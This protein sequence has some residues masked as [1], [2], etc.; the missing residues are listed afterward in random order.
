MTAGEVAAL[1]AAVA[2]SIL[3]LGL[4]V[5]LVSLISTLRALREMTEELRRTAM[6]LMNDMRSTVTHA[7]TELEKVDAL[8]IRA[9][10]ISTTVDSASR[11][12]YLAFSSPLV[13][14]IAFSAGAARA[15]QRLGQRRAED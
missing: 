11:L 13:K 14:A 6:P 10:S 1:V 8:L 4:L 9:D 12:V 2:I 15:A 3:V 7:S 5:A